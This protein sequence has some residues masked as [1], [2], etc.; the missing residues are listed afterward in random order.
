MAD[1]SSASNL[2]ATIQF[3]TKFSL[4]GLTAL[5]VVVFTINIFALNDANLYEAVNAVQ[6]FLR[7]R[8]RIETIIALGIIGAGVA[9][10]MQ[11]SSSLQNNFFIL[12]NMCPV[13]LPSTTLFLP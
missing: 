13:F 1:L 8:R 3:F 12:P 4:F 5:A 9:V 2:G 10:F 7:G 6:N 11:R